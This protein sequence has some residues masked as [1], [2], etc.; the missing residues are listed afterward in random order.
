MT[1]ITAHIPD[2]MATTLDTAAKHMNWSRSEVISHALQ[3]YLE[4][5]EDARI[6]EARLNDPSDPTLDW[7]EAKRE[8]LGTD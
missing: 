5:Y 7:E 8:L 2:E 1:Q 3:L 4:D 6:A